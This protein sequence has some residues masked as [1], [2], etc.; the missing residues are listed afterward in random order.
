M[1]EKATSVQ[2]T[3]QFQEAPGLEETGIEERP[4]YIVGKLHSIYL[5][6]SRHLQ[7]IDP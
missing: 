5:G 4:G 7:F 2:K 1:G 3:D 6:S